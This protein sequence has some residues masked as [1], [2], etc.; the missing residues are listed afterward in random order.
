MFK[1]FIR[2]KNEESKKRNADLTAEQ[3]EALTRLMK[4]KKE[5]KRAF[6]E[7][8]LAQKELDE[9]PVEIE[10]EMMK[11]KERI[12]ELRNQIKEKKEQLDKISK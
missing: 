4:S 7:R 6:A 9:A 2:K 3:Y 10:K 8:D 5:V 1:E 12:E 11:K